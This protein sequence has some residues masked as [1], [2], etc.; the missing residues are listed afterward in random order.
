MGDLIRNWRFTKDN[1]AGIPVVVDERMDKIPVTVA[2]SQKGQTPAWSVLATGLGIERR[3]LGEVLFF[4]ARLDKDSHA[5]L[6]FISRWARATGE[7]WTTPF[8]P[9]SIK[10][11]DLS[12]RELGWQQLAI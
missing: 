1:R 10:L 6:S 5:G 7:L 2:L 8:T 4:A 9:Y 11:R 12:A 3:D